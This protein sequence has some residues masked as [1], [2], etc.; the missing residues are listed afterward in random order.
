MTVDEEKTYRQIKQ[1][2][3]LAQELG[4]PGFLLE[5][6]RLLTYLLYTGSECD[7]YTP[8][9]LKI[10]KDTDKNNIFFAYDEMFFYLKWSS[11][12]VSYGDFYEDSDI[13]Y[14]KALVTLYVNDKL[15]CELAM[16]GE[17][18]LD[19][20]VHMPI[21]WKLNDITA[22]ISGSW[23]DKLKAL[24]NIIVTHGKDVRN[25]DENIQREKKAILEDLKERFGI[26]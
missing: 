15:V 1:S 14:E 5:T 13:H 18:R 20:E 23:I 16:D 10:S 6:Y 24:N 4:V 8:D 17:Q 11:L 3:Q 25:A 2:K 9:Q 7:K 12:K 26:E 22:Y 19:R 21:D